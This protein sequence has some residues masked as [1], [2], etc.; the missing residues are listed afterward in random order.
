M[1]LMRTFGET[2][3]VSG[4]VKRVLNVRQNQELM[5]P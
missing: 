4:N 2:G 3:F 1:H 5:K